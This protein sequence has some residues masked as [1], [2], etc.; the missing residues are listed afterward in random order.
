MSPTFTVYPAI[1]L[2]GGQVVRLSQGDPDR[3]TVYSADPADTARR[4]L[5]AGARWLHVVN[6]D[7]A[8]GQSGQ[9]N[10]AALAAIVAAAQAA[11]ACVQFG[12]GLRSL[13]ALVSAFAAGVQRAVLGTALIEQPQLLDAA[14]AKWGPE[15]VAAGLDARDGLVQV[16]G[17]QQGSGIAALEM[18]QDLA[19]RGL[20]WLVFTDVDRDGLQG[21]LN[22]AATRSL[23]WASGLRVIASGGVS[24]LE[25]I[26]AA[27]AAGLAGVIVG[28]ALYEG[29]LEPGGLFRP[30]EQERLC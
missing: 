3:Q 28:R 10:R 2:R 21:G 27:R 22:L 24:G 5:A 17:W 19:A 13:D 8:F 23:A 7:G 6:L 11:G 9:A 29:A 12:G 18:A 4:W 1:D 15:C 16:R 25:D 30:G 26:S 14:L 20:R